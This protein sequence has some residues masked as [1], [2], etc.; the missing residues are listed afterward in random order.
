MAAK[1]GTKNSLQ[2]LSQQPELITCDLSL[3]PRDTGTTSGIPN[4]PPPGPR[5]DVTVHPA[6]QARSPG[7]ILNPPPCGPRTSITKRVYSKPQY[8][9]RTR[10]AVPLSMLVAPPAAL[11]WTRAAAF[12]EA[13]WPGPRDPN[14]S[15]IQ[16]CPSQ[17]GTPALRM[18]SRSCRRLRV[19]V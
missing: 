14:K 16:C 11:T 3:A 13:P 8:F 2:Q 10:P 9:Q 6:A 12:P 19:P 7:A 4:I 5:R 15:H 17:A 1:P 18:K